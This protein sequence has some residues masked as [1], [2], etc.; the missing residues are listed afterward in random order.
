MKIL[1]HPANIEQI[2]S[3]LD[4]KYNTYYS[5]LITGIQFVT[6]PLM[7]KE[8][9]TG[10]YLVKGNEYYTY[11]DGNGEPPSWTIYFGFIKKEMLPLYY[12]VNEPVF[13]SR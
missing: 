5:R 13:L 8:K 7:E 10:K 12:M 11:W 6:N 2:K 3:I 4:I 1:T 9:W